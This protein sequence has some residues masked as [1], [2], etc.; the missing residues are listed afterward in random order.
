MQKM[1]I[2]GGVAL[3]GEVVVSGA[4]NSA[5]PLLMT[6]ILA[7]DQHCIKNTPDLVD[8]KT[9][10]RLLKGLGIGV[11]VERGTVRASNRGVTKREA[12]YDLVKTMRASVLCLGPLVGRYGKAKV[13]LPGGCAIGARPIDQ[14]LKGLEKLGAKVL[15]EHGYVEVRARRLKGAQIVFDMPTVTGTENILM[16]AVLAKGQTILKNAA[17]EPEVVQLADVLNSMGAKIQGAG[18]ETIIIDGVD[19]LYGAD[20][21]VIP[22]R[23]EAGTLM[24]ASAITKGNV[25]LKG[26]DLSLMTALTEKLVEAGVVIEETDKGVRV[27]GPRQLNAVDIATQPYPGFPTDMQAQFMA[28]MTLAKGSSVITERIFENRFMHVQELKR[29]GAKIR[30]EGSRAFVRGVSHLSGAEV[31]ATD[32]RASAS[33]VLAALVARGKTEVHRIYHLDRGYQR[34]GKKLRQLGAR[35]TRKKASRAVTVK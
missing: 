11:E 7:E 24:I 26:V 31:M 3:K 5:L 10:C 35:I 22:D 15:L 18:T 32:L 34:L 9:T 19:Q 14:H 12:S 25:L 6:T 8:V 29:M 30:T 17:R 23:I 1:V 33:L 16:A 2:N 28:L 27:K 21:A 4:K 20:C 13:S